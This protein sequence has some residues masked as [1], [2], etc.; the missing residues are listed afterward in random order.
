MAVNS[1][2]WNRYV[3][4]VGMVGLASGICGWVAGTIYVCMVAHYVRAVGCMVY[5]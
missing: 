3:V 4:R 2:C 1:K 5:S